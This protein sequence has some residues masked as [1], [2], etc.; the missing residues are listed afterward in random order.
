MAVTSDEGPDCV[1]DGGQEKVSI[2]SPPTAYSKRTTCCAL[3]CPSA[4][5]ALAA[6]A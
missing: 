5:C 4:F 6:Y 1:K 3:H 2:G